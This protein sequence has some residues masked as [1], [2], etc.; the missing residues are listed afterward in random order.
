[1]RKVSVNAFLDGLFPAPAEAPLRFPTGAAPSMPLLDVRSPCEF[2]RS[3]LPGAVNFPLFSDEERA[4]TGTAYKNSGRKEAV[5]LGFTLVGPRLGAMARELVAIA[6]PNR[7]LALYCSR[8]GMRSGSMAWLCAALGLRGMLLT[9][10]YKAFRRHVLRSFETRRR[11]LV[12]GGRT[13]AGKTE[14]L[15]RLAARGEQVLDLEGLAAHRGS[16]F[17]ARPDQ[18]Q[19]S[20]GHFENLL[21]MALARTDPGRPVWVED[22]SENLGAVN[23]PFAFFRQMREAP[24]FVLDVPKK[25]RLARVLDEYGAMK[26]D[27]MALCLD[28]I[29]KRLGGVAHKQAHEYL[30]AGDLAS[31]ASILLEYYDRAY[32]KQ[33]ARRPP[34]ARVRAETPEE[35]AERLLESLERFPSDPLLPP[36]MPQS[37]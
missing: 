17:G 1:M 7:S 33:L 28:R 37:V 20:P 31:L 29:K 26:R 13:G 18:G 15:H 32:D 22:E 25:A 6:G 36:G 34:A 9:G 10:G 21:S 11:L 23:V 14:T 30:A 19:P 4:D 24:V 3:H 2:M 16:A 5:C 8:G 27:H 12:L 35:A